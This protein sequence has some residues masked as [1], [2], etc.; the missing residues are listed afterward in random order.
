MILPQAGS[1]GAHHVEQ[2]DINLLPKVSL[3]GIKLNNILDNKMKIAAASSPDTSRR[4]KTDKRV[5]TML[6][7]LGSCKIPWS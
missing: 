3:L 5:T 2:T 7:L 1:K 6:N 4:Q